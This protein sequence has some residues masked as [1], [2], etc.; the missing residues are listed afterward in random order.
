MTYP[1][2][3]GEIRDGST[4]MVFSIMRG[5]AIDLHLSNRSG[6]YLPS[7]L[8]LCRSF[9]PWWRRRIVLRRC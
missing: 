4:P 3:P 7:I 6:A 5:D 1:D 8:S 9:A 2:I